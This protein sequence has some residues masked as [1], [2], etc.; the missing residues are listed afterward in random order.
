[1]DKV[2]AYVKN[3]VGGLTVA[4]VVFAYTTFAPKES[5]NELRQVIKEQAAEISDLKA[6]VKAYDAIIKYYFKPHE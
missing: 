6:E 1:M 4:A 3:A 2:Q 5:I